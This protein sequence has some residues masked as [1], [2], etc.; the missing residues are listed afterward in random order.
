M[1]ILRN[2]EQY[3]YLSSVTLKDTEQR[4]LKATILK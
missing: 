4:F 1:H 3:F 2:N